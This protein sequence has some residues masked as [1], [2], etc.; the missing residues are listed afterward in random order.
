MVARKSDWDAYFDGIQSECPWSYSANK[1]DRID[2]VYWSGITQDLD[3][4]EARVYVLYKSSQAL[5]DL[6]DELNREKP[7]YAWFW[8]HPEDE[9]LSTPEPCVIQQDRARLESIREKNKCQ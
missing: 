5:S 4:Q 1:Q 3:D 8:S 6:V 9:H 7:T 2:I